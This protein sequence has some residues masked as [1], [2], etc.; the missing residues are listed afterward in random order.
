MNSSTGD[1]ASFSS[2]LVRTAIL[3][4][5][6]DRSVRFYAEVLGLREHTYTTSGTPGQRVCW[7][8]R[9]TRIKRFALSSLTVRRWA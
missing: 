5:D 6:L 1:A 8:I 2:P 9:A 7:A 4:R 3:V